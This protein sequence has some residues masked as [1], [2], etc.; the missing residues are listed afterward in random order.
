MTQIHL[1]SVNVAR[2]EPIGIRHRKPVISGYLKRPVSADTVMVG[3]VGI[4]GDEQGDLRAHGGPEKS[5]YA[6]TADH[7]PFWTEAMSPEQP[8]G[9]GSFAEN[10]TIAGIDESGIFIGDIWQW[11]GARI[12]V[13]QPRYPCFKM[14]MATERPKIVKRF[15]AEARSG[16]YFRVLETGS[17]PTAGEIQVIAQD[18][19]GVSVRDAALALYQDADSAYRREIAAHPLLAARW[20]QMLLEAADYKDRQGV[21]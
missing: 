12:Q 20:K 21:A 6:Y 1:L 13:C 10:L 2:A 9:P 8:Y 16:I 14:A 7:F 3:P 5:V 11:G 15:L 17:A 4:D 19:A 18:R